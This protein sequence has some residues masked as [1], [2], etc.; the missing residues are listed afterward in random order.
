MLPLPAAWTYEERLPL[1]KRIPGFWDSTISV[2]GR[3]GE[4]TIHSSTA[5]YR[6][7][8]PVSV[9]RS[10]T[11][12]SHY[13]TR[14]ERQEYEPRQ[15]TRPTSRGRQGFRGV[16]TLS[17]RRLSQQISQLYRVRFFYLAYEQECYL[18]LVRRIH[19]LLLQL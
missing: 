19:S 11:D 1:E 12:T 16:C 5:W 14:P 7:K 6:P 4:D 17:H 18:I 13:T 2:S 10:Y 15:R 8:E 9:S 3:T